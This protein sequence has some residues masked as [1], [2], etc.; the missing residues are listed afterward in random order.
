MQTVKSS[1]KDKRFAEILSV[2]LGSQCALE[3]I[4]LINY[5]FFLNAPFL[6]N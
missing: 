3:T 5:I 4:S 6:N 2:F 1:N